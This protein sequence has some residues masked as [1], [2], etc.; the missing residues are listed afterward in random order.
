M[1]AATTARLSGRIVLVAAVAVVAKGGCLEDRDGVKVLVRSGD[2][3]VDTMSCLQPN[4]HVHI[5]GQVRST[6]SFLQPKGV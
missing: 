3:L 1:I 6:M 5:V 4:V 2:I